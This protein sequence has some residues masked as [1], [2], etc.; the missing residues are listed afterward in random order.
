MTRIVFGFARTSS[1]HTRL[2]P[3]VVNHTLPSAHQAPSPPLNAVPLAM[4][5]VQVTLD[6]LTTA[7]SSVPADRSPHAVGR[8]RRSLPVLA[9]SVR[10]TCCPTGSHAA[11]SWLKAPMAGRTT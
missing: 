4:L 5:V 10:Y 6:P 7:A 2:S 11:A 9:S 3:L 1:S 8:N